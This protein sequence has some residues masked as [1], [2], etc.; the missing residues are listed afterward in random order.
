MKLQVKPSADMAGHPSDRPLPGGLVDNIW[1][2]WGLM[3]G[4]HGPHLGAVGASIVGEGRPGRRTAIQLGPGRL[5]QPW[6]ARYVH[7]V[8]LACSEPQS[9]A[10]SASIRCSYPEASGLAQIAASPSKRH[11]LLYLQNHSYEVNTSLAHVMGVFTARLR[12][13]RV[14]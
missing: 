9:S 11:S 12:V 14:C 1:P 6:A 10:N 3:W 4:Q 8:H 13:C 5:G 2:G 7:E